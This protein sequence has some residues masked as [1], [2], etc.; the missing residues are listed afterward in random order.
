M[1]EKGHAYLKLKQDITALDPFPCV[2]ESS[3]RV[4]CYLCHHLYHV[5]YWQRDCDL[6][7]GRLSTA[8]IGLTI[9]PACRKITEHVP[10]TLRLRGAFLGT[11]KDEVLH[12]IRREVARAQER[13]PLECI[14]SS[15]EQGDAV[16]I[17][18]TSKRLAR[19][20]GMKI[21]RIYGRDA[22]DQW[23]HGDHC[24]IVTWH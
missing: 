18:T 3:E 13:N 23:S 14:I 10:G 1:I 5:K 19:N 21:H 7:W 15:K 24:M 2:D 22:I 9:C 17:Q 4:A 20:I 8:L 11:H 6:S 16:E 12:L